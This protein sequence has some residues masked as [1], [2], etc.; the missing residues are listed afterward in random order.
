MGKMSQQQI[1]VDLF[2]E[3]QRLKEEN[4]KLK[5]FRD[6]FDEL[7]GDGLEVAN[8]HLNGDLEPLDNFIDSAKE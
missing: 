6:Y 4:E 2:D 1:N 8:W 7:Y 5:A 3:V